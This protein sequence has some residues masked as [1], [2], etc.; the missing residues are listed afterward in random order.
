MAGPCGSN[1]TNFSLKERT[2]AVVAVMALHQRVDEYFQ[3]P[4][5]FRLR[6]VVEKYPI[7]FVVEER[8]P[9]GGAAIIA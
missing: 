1:T 8:R 6:Q 2:V 5:S 3:T 4:L 7:L 9:P